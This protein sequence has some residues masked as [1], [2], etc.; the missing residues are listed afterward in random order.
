MSPDLLPAIAS[1]ARVA[2]HGSFT[3]AASEL[4]VSTSA[5]SQNMRSLE[6]RLGARL[7]H[8]TT[9]KVSLT[10]AGARFLREAEPA[11]VALASAIEG[12][13][14]S[15]DRPAGVLRL[16]LSR[17]AAYVL[18]MPHLV[19]FLEAYPDVTV[20]MHCDNALVDLVAG[21]FDAGIRLGERLAQDMV[22]VPLGSHQRLAV[23]AAPRYLQGRATPQTPA[24][25]AHH[26]CL[27]GRLGEGLYRWEFSNEGRDFEIEVAGPLLSNDGD[28]L[29]DAARAGAG[30]AFGFEALVRDDIDAGRLVPL[31]QSWWPSFGGFYL[32]YSGRTLMPRK[33]RAFIDF[34]T[35]QTGRSASR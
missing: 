29:L 28:L 15:R 34:M 5:L 24:E 14:E 6:A 2:H 21:G 9:R 22:A 8:R 20:E 19:D 16:N 11:L 1:F 30:V 17:A 18:V 7:L 12:V 35:T 25:L 26:R 31:L 32:Y 10:E 3:R 33:L 13:D 23:V 4:G 27:N